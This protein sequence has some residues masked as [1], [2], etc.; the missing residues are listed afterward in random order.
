[1]PRITPNSLFKFHVQR[2]FQEASAFIADGLKLELRIWDPETQ[3]EWRVNPNG[4]YKHAEPKPIE[5]PIELE[6]TDGGDEAE[7]GER[8]G[9]VPVCGG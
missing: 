9:E 3:E 2:F 6:V 7:E 8:V 1:M 5:I 4:T